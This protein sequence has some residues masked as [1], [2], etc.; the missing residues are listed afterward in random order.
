MITSFCKL[1]K[2]KTIL[3]ILF[4]IFSGCDEN[5]VE[6]DICLDSSQNLPDTPISFMLQDLNTTSSTYAQSVGPENWDGEI[7]LFYFS[8]NEQ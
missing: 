2:M 6:V 5:P 7:R 1:Q 3:I 8:S 4:F